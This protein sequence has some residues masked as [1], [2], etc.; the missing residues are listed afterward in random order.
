MP[1]N[2]IVVRAKRVR[3]WGETI[4]DRAWGGYYCEQLLSLRLQYSLG[5]APAAQHQ[6]RTQCPVQDQV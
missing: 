4:V 1:I 6:A 2:H 3:A 5:L